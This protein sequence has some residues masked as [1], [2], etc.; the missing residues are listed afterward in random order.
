MQKLWVSVEKLVKIQKFSDLA[1]ISCPLLLV[2]R[3]SIMNTVRQSDLY[4]DCIQNA[5]L[6]KKLRGAVTGSINGY[7]KA[8]CNFLLRPIIL[9]PEAL[10]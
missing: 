9:A 1:E 3:K 6:T 4:L 5:C 8:F 10:N 2:D 7:Q